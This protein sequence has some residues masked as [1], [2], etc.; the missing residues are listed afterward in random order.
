MTRREILSLMGAT[1]GAGAFSGTTLLESGDPRWDE[2]PPAEGSIMTVRGPIA[3]TELGTAL[4]HEH[5]LSRFGEPPA[6]HPDYQLSNLFD[7]VVPI[8]EQLKSLGCDAIMDCT[9]AYFGRAP[10]VMH[11]LAEL[12][13]L[14]LLTNTGYYGAVDDRYVPDH[15]YDETAAEIADRWV[16]EWTEGLEGTGIRPGFIKTAVDGGP[17]SDI[18]RRLVRAAAKTH[19]ETG[20]TIA[21][22]TSDNVPAAQE[23]LSV[24]E[25]EGVQPSAWIWVHAQNVDDLDA[26][27]R[28]ASRGAWIEF[29]GL[30][31]GDAIDRHLRLVRA[32]RDRDLLDRVLLSHDGSSY[33]PE[34]T[35][36][37]PMDTLFQSFSSTL[38]SAGFSE[39]EIRTLTVDNPRRAFT[40]RVRN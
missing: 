34:G 3:P 15:T 36:P 39:S 17:L 23:Q 38:R 1:L 33:P 35:E 31:P 10:L 37:R 26:L 40:V 25:E 11:R 5:I 22:H 24:L 9:A 12:T 4:P 21:V 20:L 16:T 29:D 18:D 14:H 27:A 19:A 2:R 30:A 28:A 32:M 6:R 7:T 8:L 13:G